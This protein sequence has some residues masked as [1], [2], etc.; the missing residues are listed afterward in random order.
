MNQSPSQEQFRQWEPTS[1]DATS[2]R[3]RITQQ[4]LWSRRKTARYADSH[5]T[6]QARNRLYPRHGLSKQARP[7]TPD[8]QENP[9]RPDRCRRILHRRS[10][11]V[12]SQKPA[13]DNPHS[14]RKREHTVLP[15]TL[16]GRWPDTVRIRPRSDKRD[17]RGTI[18]TDKNRP[19]T[20]LKPERNT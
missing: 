20:I 5:E 3:N 19:D 4:S 10:N 18:P 2:E 1:S 13:R 7:E 11:Q 12:R 14:S 8:G 6:V 16:D 15:Q 17:E 9:H